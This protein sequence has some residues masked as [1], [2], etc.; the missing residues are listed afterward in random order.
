MVE[1]QFEKIESV[2]PHVARSVEPHVRPVRL[3]VRDAQR[4]IVEQRA[5]ALPRRARGC[6]GLDH[7][8]DCRAEPSRAR[9]PDARGIYG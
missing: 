3:E 9:E 5:H 4:V 1:P 6:K 8:M 7:N 2:K